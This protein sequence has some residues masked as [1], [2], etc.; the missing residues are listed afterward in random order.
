[1]R[2]FLYI[3]FLLCF[4]NAFGHEGN[5]MKRLEKEIWYRGLSCVPVI[6]PYVEYDGEIEFKSFRILKLRE[7]EARFIH[8]GKKHIVRGQCMGEEVLVPVLVETIKP[9]SKISEKMVRLVYVE[10]HKVKKEHIVD[11]QDIVGMNSRR[12]I[13]AN[14][15]V[16]HKDLYKDWAVKRG[17]SVKAFVISKGLSI[18]V[19]AISQENGNQGD[20]IKIKNSNTILNA[21]VI[22]DGIVKCVQ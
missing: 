4:S 22:G 2:Y 5:F 11:L 3:I 8:M 15:P 13:A 18:E 16:F 12:T 10:K 17:Q 7:F 6:E 19:Q 21:I 20:T 1:M 9:H 14:E